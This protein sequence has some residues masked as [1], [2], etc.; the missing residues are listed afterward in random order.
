MEKESF[1]LFD[2]ET[3]K[4]LKI[5]GIKNE[6]RRHWQSV[7]SKCKRRGETLI[8]NKEAKTFHC[9]SCG[10]KGVLKKSWQF[11]QQEREKKMKQE[12]EIPVNQGNPVSIEDKMI[13]GNKIEANVSREGN[14]SYSGLGIEVKYP[15]SDVQGRSNDA[16]MEIQVENIPRELKD[17]THW[18]VWRWEEN[19]DDKLTKVPYQSKN[20]LH[21]A[22]STNSITWSTFKEAIQAYKECENSSISGIGF[23][24]TDSPFT[25]I[26]L[27]HCRDAESGD[28]KP[29]ASEIIRKMKSYNEV[30]PSKTGIR[31]WIKGKPMRGIKKGNIEIY[32]EGRY[33]TVTGNRIEGYKVIESRQ[34]ELDE[35]F[36]SLTMKD[37]KKSSIPI[38][39]SDS[40]ALLSDEEILKKASTAKNG[41]DFSALYRGESNSY[42]SQSEADLALCSRLAFWANRDETTIDRLFRGS[43]LMRDKWDERH[44]GNGETYGQHT[45]KTAIEGTIEVYT[46]QSSKDSPKTKATSSPLTQK[47]AC[48]PVIPNLDFPREAIGGLAGQFAEV[49]SEHLES[50]YS[51][52]VF[53]Y[54]TCLGNLIGD[55]VTLAS[56]ITPQPRFYTITIGASG[57]ARKSEAQK[58]TVRFFLDTFVKGEFNVCQGV[59]SAEGLAVKINKIEQN[60]KRLLL[61]YDEAKS[62][63]NKARIDGSTLLPCVNTFFES[64]QFHSATKSHD[65]EIDNAYLSMLAASTRETFEKMWTSDFLDI[66]FINRLWLV[67]DQAER[68]FSI[69][70]EVPHSDLELMRK[71]LIETLG[72]IPKEGLKLD[73]DED[74][75]EIFDGWYLSDESHKSPLS[76]RLDTYGLRL[77]ILL[78][79]NEWASTISAKISENVVKLLE[80]QLQI[81]RECD[82]IDAETNVAKV[83]E[84]ARRALN[85]GPLNP[86]NLKIKVNYSRYGIYIF[87]LAIDNLLKEKEIFLDSK[88]NLYC[89][90]G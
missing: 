18:V 77:M 16:E 2:T 21:L 73:I 71:K 88:S 90:R 48:A 66:G 58:K 60:P 86:R 45:V 52:F 76:K 26:D 22:Q 80:W 72:D 10:W 75:R 37:E 5:E 24:V 78:A 42:P 70:R 79:V 4:I 62:Y 25:G 47:D 89:L 40:C 30:T 49:Y 17:L 19:K 8:I 23:V 36:Q 84:L 65:I 3:N 81:R 14:V 57:D 6:S 59:G 74:G 20:P 9:Y 69:P 64:N 39:K 29:W 54:L 7:C 44:Y 83:E 68:R 53:D 46:P 41:E 43:G 32:G 13:G 55:R 56:E 31:I 1:Y 35:L 82:V 50:P 27:D 15:S 61:V 38:D 87:Q 33:F 11:E 63:V 12:Q 51:F 85:K 34:N 28:I 67:Y